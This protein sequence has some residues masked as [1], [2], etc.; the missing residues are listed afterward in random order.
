MFD[1]KALL[2][3]N[4][5]QHHFNLVIIEHCKKHQ[6]VISE[7]TLEL[8][9][10]SIAALVIWCD[11]INGIG[12]WHDSLWANRDLAK[13]ENLE[14]KYYEEVKKI[15]NEKNPNEVI[16]FYDSKRTEYKNELNT[17]LFHALHHF[18]Y[19]RGQITLEF[20]KVG[21][22]PIPSDYIAYKR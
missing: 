3:F 16:T 13:M 2:E 14:Q 11:R 8:L 10:H 19:H 5:Y 7:R 17:I 21:L 6:T 1:K 9:N 15:L 18:T 12:K 4:E 20:R 22:E